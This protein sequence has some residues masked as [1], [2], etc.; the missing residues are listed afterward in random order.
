MDMGLTSRPG[1]LWPRVTDVRM[2]DVMETTLVVVGCAVMGV[3]IGSFLTVVVDRVPRGASVVSPPS[4]CGS[5]G[6]QLGP[7]DLVPVLSWL[8]LRG[9]C[10]QCGTAIG[11]EPIAIELATA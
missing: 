2:L 10:R 6:L 4:A 5:C 8:V 3:V 7:R 9:K 1:H 11:I